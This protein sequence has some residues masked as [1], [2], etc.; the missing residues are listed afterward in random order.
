ML[1][2]RSGSKILHK[3]ALWTLT[4]L[5]S[6]LLAP[7]VNAKD[8]NQNDVK[9]YTKNNADLTSAIAQMQTDSKQIPYARL[10]ENIRQNK[11]DV[12]NIY[13]VSNVN[14][15]FHNIHADKLLMDCS[16]C[17]GLKQYKIDYL[18]VSKHKK[19]STEHKG[20]VEKAVCLGCH[21]PGGMGTPWYGGSTVNETTNN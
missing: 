18:L 11:V 1:I 9:G 14:A 6:T 20:R 16:H 3:L 7:L 2:Q 17:H 4:V 13:S 5:L 8:D 10:G 19:I 12:G 15:R 21:L